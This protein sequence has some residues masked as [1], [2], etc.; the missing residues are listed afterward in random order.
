M[1][2]ELETLLRRYRPVGPPPDLRARVIGRRPS[3]GDW[4]WLAAAAALAVVTVLLRTSASNAMLT[5]LQTTDEAPQ[6]AVVRA[7]AASLD[8]EE[9]AGVLAETIILQ[10]QVR[11]AHAGTPETSNPGTSNQ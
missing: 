1:P 11:A 10:E 3:T 2:E 9:H 4:A 8:P 5:A 6:T 7:L